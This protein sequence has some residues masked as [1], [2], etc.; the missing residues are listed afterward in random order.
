ML[1]TFKNF[2]VEL[3]K[4]IKCRFVLNIFSSILYSNNV[5]WQVMAFFLANIRLNRQN[6]QK[7]ISLCEK[8]T[9]HHIVWLCSEIKKKK[10]LQMCV[11]ELVT[12]EVNSFF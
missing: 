3:I 6:F 2:K 4:Y 8:I 1:S 9:K 5:L 7:V 12:N 11:Y 10:K